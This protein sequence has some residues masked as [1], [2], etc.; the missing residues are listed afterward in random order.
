MAQNLHCQE[1]SSHERTSKASLRWLKAVVPSNL[2]LLRLNAAGGLEDAV[3]QLLDPCVD[4]TVKHYYYSGWTPLSWAAI[5]GHEAVVRL[6]LQGLADDKAKVGR[7]R[8]PLLWAAEKGHT[9]VVRL[10]LDNGGKVDAKDDGCGRTPLSWAAEKGHEAGMRLLLANYAD[11]EA[12][13]VFGR[14]PK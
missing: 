10:L 12:K 9:T 4:V 11:L 13:D 3:Q 2:M 1:T 7:T 6:Q 5:G 14:T 8:M